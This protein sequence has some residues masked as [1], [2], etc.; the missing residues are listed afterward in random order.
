MHSVSFVGCFPNN[1]PNGAA[2]GGLRGG[3]RWVV[4][5]RAVPFICWSKGFYSLRR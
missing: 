4:D 5:L 1:H 2:V 3:E